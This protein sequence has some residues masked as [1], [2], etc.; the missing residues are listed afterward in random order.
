VTADARADRVRRAYLG[1]WRID[2]VERAAVLRPL[3]LSRVAR[4]VAAALDAAGAPA[5]ASVAVIL[6]DDAELADLNREHLGVDGATDVLSFPMQPPGA[7]PRS[8]EGRRSL[9]TAP[10]R[11]TTARLDPAA[12]SR[13]THVGDIAVSVERAITQAQAGLGGQTGDVRW[14]AADEVRLLVT[15]GTLH[16]CGW[17]HAEPDDEAAMRALERDLLAKEAPPPR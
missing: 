15:H 8:P 7:Y 11:A 9:G 17:D 5:P 16:L 14:S 12:P 6:S 4:A 3:A 13:R 10:D 2:I 1:S